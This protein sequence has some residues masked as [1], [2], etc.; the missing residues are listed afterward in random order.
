MSNTPK[1]TRHPI[2]IVVCSDGT[3]NH[4]IKSRGTN[5][6]KLYEAVDI[7]GHHDD[8]RLVRQLAFYDGGVG[9]TGPLP[10]RILGSA[11][12]F[13]F[14]ANV[15][16]LYRA[17]IEV[18]QHGDKLY[19]FGFSRGAFTVRALSGLIDCAGLFD[20]S[21]MSPSQ[22]DG[23][24]ADRWRVFEEKILSDG[25]RKKPGEAPS[26]ESLRAE[27]VITFLGVWDTVGAVG[28]PLVDLTRPRNLI[29]HRLVPWIP[30]FGDGSPFNVVA[31]ACQ[32]LALDDART[33]FRPELWQEDMNDSTPGR[34]NQVWFAGAHA[35]VGGGYPRH[36]M[37]L[38]T[39]DWMMREAEEAGLRFIPSDR[40]S[41]DVH[42]DVHDRL[43][44]SRAGLGVYYRWQPRR[45]VALSREQGITRP[46]VHESVFERAILKTE[47]YAPLNVPFPCEVVWTR[48]KGAAA[49]PSVELDIEESATAI[50]P[51]LRG[52][53]NPA[54][55][56]R[57]AR[58]TDQFAMQLGVGIL[59][60][61]SMHQ[62]VPE[63]WES[64][65]EAGWVVGGLTT[66]GLVIAQQLVRFSDWGLRRGWKRYREWRGFDDTLEANSPY[67]S[68]LE[69]ARSDIEA[70]KSSYRLFVVASLASLLVT[71]G[72]YRTAEHLSLVVV[73][74]LTMS[75]PAWYVGS[76]VDRRLAKR[77]AKFWQNHRDFIQRTLF[78]P[79]TG[80]TLVREGEHDTATESYQPRRSMAVPKDAPDRQDEAQPKAG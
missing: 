22:V 64:G 3:G 24:I 78:P 40:A 27:R 36:G 43:Y 65:W 58:I 35:N 77:G 70:G 6:F 41:I 39:L 51:S 9:T 69:Q 60:G 19:L 57:L 25:W 32:A 2:N 7:H 80:T 33:T 38:V 16:R 79:A 48:P 50:E 37:S 46:K 75:V 14:S 45:V 13:G 62:E 15:R 53:T 34:V 71:F 74:V 63:S 29:L 66:V 20:P 18:Y 56:D 55:T 42:R 76:V 8:S 47:G 68:L 4:D 44:D 52:E 1:N 54:F 30:W 49:A 67:R 72:L 26:P 11:F 59:V 61:I 5:V 21:G 12:G 17:I 31:R 23:A 73:A 10:L 28:F